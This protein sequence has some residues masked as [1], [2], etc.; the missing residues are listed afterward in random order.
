MNFLEK[1][2]LLKKDF[3]DTKLFTRIIGGKNKIVWPESSGVYVIWRNDSNSIDNLIYIGMT[4]KYSRNKENDK[5]SFNKA[6]F[7]SRQGRSTPY[8]FCQSKKDKGNKYEFYFRYGPDISNVDKQSKIKYDLDAYKASI[9]YTELEIHCFHLNDD[10]EEY[11]PI[12]LESILLTKY[13]KSKGT[14][15]PANN[16]L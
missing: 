10:H 8:R 6:L 9:P 1:Y 14:L 12:L 16:S 5:V 3:L 13:I 15:P 11:T 2:D 4:G 7:K